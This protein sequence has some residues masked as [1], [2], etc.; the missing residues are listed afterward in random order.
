MPTSLILASASAVRQRLL[1]NAQVPFQSIASHVDETAIKNTCRDAGKNAAAT[2]HELAVA[3]AMSVS[4]GHPGALVLG[5]DQMLTCGPD[6]YDKPDG[7]AGVRS[8]L[9]SLRGRVHQL[10]NA[11]VIIENQGLVWRHDDEITMHMRELSDTFIETYVATVGDTAC[12]SVGAYQL[13]GLGGQ[14]FD[15]ADGDFFS[16]LG[17]PL[18]AVMTYLRERGILSR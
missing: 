1:D 11:T 7:P 8:H 10:V 6:W 12:Q 16:I 13:E 4:R 18:L 5:A 9:R 2:A 3:K 15:R 17:L 14:L